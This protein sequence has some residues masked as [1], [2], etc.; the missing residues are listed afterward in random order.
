MLGAELWMSS[1]A[2]L[3]AA[4]T[5]PQAPSGVAAERA[6]VRG[7]AGRFERPGRRH[8]TE[9][10]TCRINHTT[11]HEGSRPLHRQ[12]ENPDSVRAPT[13]GR[14][15]GSAP[16]VTHALKIVSQGTR[17]AISVGVRPRPSKVKKG[18]GRVNNNNT[19]VYPAL[20][21]TR[22]DDTLD[23]TQSQPSRRGRKGG[24]SVEVIRRYVRQARLN[25]KRK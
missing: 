10:V 17:D 16:S 13:S 24:G 7:D 15:D 25:S 8:T 19:C 5:R 20:Y 1:R 21:T 12:H 23:N 3:Q 2:S 18:G 22:R 9:P 4:D 14:R 11:A 6:G